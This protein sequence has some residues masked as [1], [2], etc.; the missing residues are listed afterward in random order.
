MTIRNPAE[1]PI[2]RFAEHLRRSGKDREALL[3]LIGDGEDAS[4][5]ADFARR[6]GYPVAPEEVAAFFA[7]VADERSEPDED[8]LLARIFHH[9]SRIL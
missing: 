7:A 1:L 2:V 8:G 3:T 9:S 6:R 5:I 4:V